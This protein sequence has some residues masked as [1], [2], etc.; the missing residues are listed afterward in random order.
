MEALGEMID[1]ARQAFHVH[2]TCAVPSAPD[3]GVGTPPSLRGFSFYGDCEE[4][5]RR[6]LWKAYGHTAAFRSHEPL[7]L[8]HLLGTMVGLSAKEFTP[9]HALRRLST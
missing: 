5:Y 8:Q 3:S 2:L 1:D 7:C 9:K 6:D 4:R